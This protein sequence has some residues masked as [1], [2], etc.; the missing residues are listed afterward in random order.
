MSD[1][2]TPT[3][4]RVKSRGAS[5]PRPNLENTTRLPN[6]LET[7]DVKKMNANLSYDNG[8]DRKQLKT[9]SNKSETKVQLK[10]PAQLNPVQKPVREHSIGSKEREDAT[11]PFVNSKSATN[12]VVSGM[13]NR[14]PS[15][16]ISGTIATDNESARLSNVQPYKYNTITRENLNAISNIRKV[17]PNGPMNAP[18]P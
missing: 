15:G 10:R 6:K 16:Y 14:G 1:M 2:R 13:I 8:Y 4:I 3:N 12:S 5:F 7:I 18:L 17:S 9:I 11:S